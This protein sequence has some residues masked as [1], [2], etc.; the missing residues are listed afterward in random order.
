MLTSTYA[1]LKYINIQKSRNTHISTKLFLKF[2]CFPFSLLNFGFTIYFYILVLYWVF[3]KHKLGNST[4]DQIGKTAF[5]AE[6]LTVS[7]NVIYIYIYIYIQSWKQCALLGYHHNGFVA[8]HALGHMMYM[9]YIGCMIFFEIWGLYICIYIY[10]HTYIY[11]YICIYI[12][13]YIY[14]Y[15]IIYVLLYYIYHIFNIGMNVP[16]R[17]EKSWKT[18]YILTVKCFLHKITCYKLPQHPISVIPGHVDVS[19]SSVYMIHL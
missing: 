19:K 1:Y 9:M 3:E 5:T 14:I 15:Y 11:I 2:L 12:Y 4:I 10:I 13:N 7:N 8:T 6:F 16:W 18:E 17:I